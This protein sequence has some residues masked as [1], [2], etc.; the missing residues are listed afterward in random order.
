MWFLVPS[1]RSSSLRNSAA[2]DTDGAVSSTRW[3]PVRPPLCTTGPEPETRRLGPPP[4]PPLPYSAFAEELATLLDEHN[5]VEPAVIV[6]HSIGG[7]IAR[8]FAGLWPE[9]CCG[10]VFVD[11][12]IPQFKLWW[13]DTEPVV[14]GDASGGATEFDILAGEVEVLSAAIPSVPTIVITRRRHWWIAGK[15]TPHPAIDDLW[16]ISQRL[17]A[18]QHNALLIVAENAGHQIP[19]EAP[20]LVAYAVDVV[21]RAARTGTAPVVDVAVL[22]RQRG[23]AV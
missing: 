4:N 15:T 18:E 16:W 2:R 5:I 3:A 7:H 14:D 6:G 23:R 10:L 9:R 11:A 19:S 13:R 1:L 12:S 22:V 20:G 17:L 8:A 21:V